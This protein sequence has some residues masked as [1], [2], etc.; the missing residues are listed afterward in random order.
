MAAADTN[1]AQFTGSALDVFDFGLSL[2]P[3]PEVTTTVAPASAPTSSPAPPAFLTP[4]APAT[5][6]LNL[7]LG[8]TTTPAIS[9][10]LPSFLTSP[11]AATPLNLGL[12]AA[13]ASEP[14]VS[15]PLNLGLSPASTPSNPQVVVEDLSFLSG[16]APPGTAGT[17]PKTSSSTVSPS[18]YPMGGMRGGEKAADILTFSSNRPYLWE[19]LLLTPSAVPFQQAHVESMLRVAIRRGQA[20]RALESAFELYRLQEVLGYDKMAKS[21]CW[22][23]I[24]AASE[25]IS[26]AS[27]SLA[28]LALDTCRRWLSD[29][30]PMTLM[31]MLELVWKMALTPKTRVTEKLW[32]L[33]SVKD[34]VSTRLGLS[35]D[36]T[37]EERERF[38]NPQEVGY[39][40]FQPGDDMELRALGVLFYMRLAAR[41]S[42]C[43]YFLYRYLVR[44]A[45]KDKPAFATRTGAGIKQPELALHQMLISLYGNRACPVINAAMNAYYA[46]SSRTMNDETKNYAP[47]KSLVVFATCCYLFSMDVAELPLSIGLSA[48]SPVHALVQE[49]IPELY[50]GNYQLTV[51]RADVMPFKGLHRRGQYNYD[52]ALYYQLAHEDMN[53]SLV[54]Y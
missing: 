35:V 45:H 14:S 54:G 7:G 26:L 33:F 27:P 50:Q 37:E 18:L 17:T 3:V 28:G 41:D 25:D 46:A 21:L 48:D 34:N 16:G 11:A 36:L 30:T 47:R 52:A 40:F 9:S 44:A 22:T 49:L 15:V 24:W 1:F 38:R 12:S 8:L 4:P 6:P 10:T 19:S 53:F 32:E 13:P 2:Q 20:E 31:N 39:S 43:L 5:A 23:L 51:D 29:K 42:S